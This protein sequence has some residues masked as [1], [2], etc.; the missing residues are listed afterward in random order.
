M[1]GSSE[2]PC[3]R[4]AADP[5]KM[6]AMVAWM[7]TLVVSMSRR[8]GAMPGQRIISGIWAIG[9]YS[10]TPGLPKMSRSPREWP[11]AG[12]RVTAGAAGRRLGSG[13]AGA[14]AFG[15][16]RVENPAQPMVDHRQLGAV[17]VAQFLRLGGREHAALDRI[18]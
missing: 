8:P 11:W 6:S 12:H 13:G 14:E 5:P 3:V 17:V 10:G 16:D 4:C 1:A 7:S 9:W 15:V 2:R 18:H